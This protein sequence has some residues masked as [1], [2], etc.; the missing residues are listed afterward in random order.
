M[1]MEDG[2]KE[3]QNKMLDFERRKKEFQAD[4]NLLE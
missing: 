2:Q 1:T 4:I 3:L